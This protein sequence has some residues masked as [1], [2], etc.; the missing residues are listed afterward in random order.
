LAGLVGLSGCP[1]NPYKA[2]SWT[3]KLGGREHERAVQE[4]EQLGDPSAIPEL[5][6]VWV[7]QGKPVRDLQVIIGLARPL[8]PKEAHDKFFTDYEATGREASW[9]KALPFLQQALTDVDEA[10]SRS[11]DSAT[12]AAEA[13]GESQLADGLPALVS[14]M[15]TC[16][17]D[18]S[19]QKPEKL[20]WGT[21]WDC[22]GGSK[23][24]DRAVTKKLYQ[25]QVAAIRAIGN[26]TNDKPPASTALGRFINRDP[27]LN[28]RMAKDKAEGRAMEEKFGMYLGVTGASINALGELHVP[29]AA[30]MLVLSLY[31]TP[32]LTTQV[33]RALVASGPTA[34][35]EL[36]K[37]LAGTHTEVEALFKAKKLDKYCGDKGDAPADQCQPVT[38]RDFYAAVVLGDFYDPKTVPDL[39]NALKRPPAPAYYVD[40]QAGPTQYNA[41]FDALRKI[42]SG[43]AAAPVRAMWMTSAAGKVTPPK[44]GQAAAPAPQTADLATKILAI[45][46]YA[47]VTRDNTGVEELGKIAADNSADDGLRQAAAEAFA[48]LSRNSKDIEILEVLAKKYFDASD[49]KRKEADGKPKADADAADKVFNDAKKIVDEAKAKVLTTTRD[50]TKSAKDI[51]DATNAAKKAEDDFKVAKKKHKDATQ[52]FKGADGAAKAYKGYARMFQTHIA[53]IEIAIRCKDD[54]KCYAASLSLTPEMVEANM[55]PY[56]KDLGAWTTD[57]KLGLRE[58]NIERGMLEIGKKGAAAAGYTDLLLDKATS[59]NRLIRQSILLALP[60]IAAVPCAT[61]EEK[62]GKAIKAGEG[63]TTLGELNLETQMLRHYFSWAGGKTPSAKGQLDTPAEKPAEKPAKSEPAEKPAKAEPAKTPPAKTPPAKTPPKKKGR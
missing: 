39:L 49:K 24:T 19:T 43:D 23:P 60:K 41:I 3:K 32:E 7:E 58:G 28:P 44:R 51:K 54:L 36:K 5:G 50:T 30:S 2:S 48:R 10:N 57:E 18:S 22:A 21:S 29:T 62:L 25:A 14:L 47:F 37:I 13:L 6:R 40:E 1:D 4:L 63:K 38:A 31:R 26:Y 42:G 46:A 16:P 9:D 8:T 59:D 52:P 11:V 61:C 15:L 33:R 17:N 12:K 53:R 27:E 20:K 45:S 35:E 56:I 55:K 34:K